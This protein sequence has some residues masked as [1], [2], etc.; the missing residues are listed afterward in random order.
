[1]SILRKCGMKCSMKCGMCDFAFSIL[2]TA[3]LYVIHR[4]MSRI[5]RYIVLYTA[6]G[7]YVRTL[8]HLK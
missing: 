6:L 2:H 4:E 7:T 5:Q 8:V 3:V 1:M